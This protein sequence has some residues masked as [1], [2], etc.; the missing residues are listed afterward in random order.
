MTRLKKGAR[1]ALC[2]V[3]KP[4]GITSY[5]ELITQ[6]A[7]I[8]GFI[9]FDYADRFPEALADLGK[10]IAEGRIVRKYHIVQGL[11]RAPEALSLLF[12]G[13]N[14]GKLVVHVSDPEAKLA[15]LD[16]PGL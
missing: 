8:E 15:N 10:W 7:K 12:T 4:K 2:D 6:R 16:N 14:T 11:E 5:L 13:D 9:V 1:I 3:P